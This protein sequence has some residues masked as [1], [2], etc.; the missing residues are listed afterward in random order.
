MKH[1]SCLR[2][3]LSRPVREINP[4]QFL[5]GSCSLSIGDLL[6]FLSDKSW[7]VRKGATY[8]L[9]HIPETSCTPILLH[10][11]M[12]DPSDSVA[13]QAHT[14]LTRLALNGDRSLLRHLL[15][16]YWLSSSPSNHRTALLFSVPSISL[17]PHFKSILLDLSGLTPPAIHSKVRYE[18]IVSL[19]F[20]VDDNTVMSRLL[21][22]AGKGS[23]EVQTAALYALV[24]ST[25]S[26]AI[27]LFYRIL[28]STEYP[29]S[30]R[31]VAS[32]GLALVRD[33]SLLHS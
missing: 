14:S 21:Y 29:V 30:A 4:D 9:G 32:E 7:K 25:S 26:E 23:S 33:C 6:Q 3:A 20:F 15:A 5:S 1:I 22:L 31:L 28:H 13:I 19:G 24:N 11:I 16:I 17:I 10:V 8:L 12:Y 27:S 2:A 18:A